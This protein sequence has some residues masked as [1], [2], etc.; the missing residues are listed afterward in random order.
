MGTVRTIRLA[1]DG[2]VRGYT[3][4]VGFFGHSVGET[5]ADLMALIGAAATFPG[6]GFLVPTRNAESL[7]RCLRHGL[8][9][10]QPMMLMSSG[11]YDE[12]SGAFLPSI[13]Y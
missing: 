2:R 8:R 12:P 9:I 3:T 6:P 1:H 11:R 4:G 10:V 5:T 7:R 13:L